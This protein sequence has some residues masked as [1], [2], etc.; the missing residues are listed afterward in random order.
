MRL[1]RKKK[2]ESNKDIAERILKL[3]NCKDY[4]ICPPPTDP[5]VAFNELTR[6]LLGEDF[7]VDMPLCS[8]QCNTEIL[9]EI[10]YVYKNRRPKRN[11]IGQKIVKGK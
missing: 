1:F 4:D 9:C 3:T 10:E 8:T 7:Y 6:Y 11:S 2:V 5:Q